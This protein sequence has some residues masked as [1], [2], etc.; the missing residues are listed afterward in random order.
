LLVSLNSPAATLQCGTFGNNRNQV[1]HTNLAPGI[2]VA[3]VDIMLNEF[4]VVNAAER[5]YTFSSYGVDGASLQLLTLSKRQMTLLEISAISTYGATEQDGWTSKGSFNVG[6]V[7]VENQQKSFPHLGIT[8]NRFASNNTASGLRGDISVKLDI[9][10]SCD[11]DQDTTPLSYQMSLP[12]YFYS[13]FND[14]TLLLSAQLNYGQPDLQ[15]EADLKFVMDSLVVIPSTFP[16]LTASESQNTQSSEKPTSSEYQ[17]YY[18]SQQTNGQTTPQSDP[19]YAPQTDPYY[20]PQSDQTYIPQSDQTYIPQND[21]YY[22]PQA[23]QSYT[24]QAEQTYVPQN[25]QYYAPQSERNYY[26]S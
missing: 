1:L 8:I 19:Y 9:R 17:D 16:L 7:L 21:Q 25:D 23:E 26:Q 22:A 18:S 24:P 4:P 6:S 5:K 11:P 12:A 14:A 3:L 13:K 10:A 2:Y 15:F 20:A